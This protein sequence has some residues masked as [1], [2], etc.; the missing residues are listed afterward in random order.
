MDLSDRRVYIIN[1]LHIAMKAFPFSLRLT[2]PGILLLMGC[3]AGGFSF[4]RQVDLTKQRAES[5]MA[6]D[7]RATASTTAQLLEYLYR[8]SDI[9]NAQSE[10]ISLV[11]SRLARDLNLDLALF[12]DQTNRIRNASRYELRQ[13]SLNTTSLAE[14]APVVERV[15]RNLVGE[16]VVSPR[17]KPDSSHL[18]G[19]TAGK[20]E[21]NAL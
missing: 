7:A 9:E 17:P 13:Q 5:E 14:L 12:C 1:L 19:S 3:V 6:R 15:R 4:Q 20:S 16:I 2:L 21:G 10:G 18:S 11:I 8:R